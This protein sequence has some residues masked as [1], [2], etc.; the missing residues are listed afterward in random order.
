MRR[1]SAT[2][3]NGWQDVAARNWDPDEPDQ[4]SA[5]PIVIDGGVGGV[6]VRQASGSWIGGPQATLAPHGRGRGWGELGSAERRVPIAEICEDLMSVEHRHHFHAYTAT[7]D[8][9]VRGS[10]SVVLTV[11]DHPKFDEAAQGRMLALF[12]HTQR[13]HRLL[14]R[15][16]ALFLDALDNDLIARNSEG[17]QFRLLIHSGAGLEMQVLR[18]RS[19]RDHVGHLAPERDG[20]GTLVCPQWAL[21]KIKRRAQAR[22]LDANPLLADEHREQSQLDLNLLFGRTKA[23]ETE[24]LRRDN[25][26]WMEVTA[27]DLAPLDVLGADHAA[28]I[29]EE[30]GAD[31][32]AESFLATPLSGPFAT[33]LATKLRGRF[34]SL[35]L[36]DWGSIARGALRA[37]QLIE[38]GLP[39]Y[40]DRLTPIHLAVMKRDDPYF[41]DLVGTDATL[42]ANREYVSPIYHGLTWGRGKSEIDFYVLKGNAEVRHWRARLDE[43]PRQDVKVELRLRQTPGQSWAKLSLTSPEWEPLQRNPIFLDWK[44][45]SAVDRTPDE[46]LAGLRSPPP[47]IP[48]RI[49]EHPSWELWSGSPNHYGLIPAIFE[50]R[51]AGRVVPERIA[52]LL[53]RSIRDPVTRDRFRPVGTDGKLPEELSGAD[54][55]D[56]LKLLD[57][58]SAEICPAPGRNRRPPQ[59]NDRIRCL[60]WAFTLCPDLVQ[61]AIVDALEADQETRRH[62][63][64]VPTHA[65][66]VLTQGAGRAVAGPERIRR[67]LRILVARQTNTDTLNALAMI[68]SRRHE[69]PRSLT[70]DLVKQIVVLL[71]R[72]LRSLQSSAWF[73]TR[74]KNALSALAGLFRYREVEPYALLSGRDPIAQQVRDTLAQIDHVLIIHAAKI[75]DLSEKRAMIA[76]LQ[77]HL[78]GRG[79]PNILRRIDDLED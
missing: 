78:D 55:A 77:D 6:A 16:V 66:R 61:D 3:V 65:R 2:D 19:A 74:F 25:G 30:V 24:I 15:S 27:P 62:P 18:L 57:E 52:D 56:F 1:L 71:G 23:G 51:K 54:R 68:L 32:V 34:P 63:L 49:V 17:A 8:S 44:T 9:L 35:R 50:M 10:D 26:T 22:I 36:L 58:F 21:E 43:P 75:P 4:P 59:D 14:W 79:D 11:P 42:P 64:L 41:E 29:E 39:H 13:S 46:I 67:V 31:Q 37:A 45:I 40:F 70:E 33:A 38:R 5:A 48:E 12:R 60:T 53:S 69:A 73:K 20:Y 7:I 72:E 47:S 76:G 28:D